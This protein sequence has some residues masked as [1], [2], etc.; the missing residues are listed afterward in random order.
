MSEHPDL[1]GLFHSLSPAA[2]TA[3][4]V[5]GVVHPHDCTVSQLA[6][7]LRHA[8][9]A[10]H[11]HRLTNA[12]LRDADRELVES[13]LAYAPRRGGGLRASPH[14]APWLTMQAH[15]AGVLDRIVAGHGRVHPRLSY[16][17]DEARTAMALRCCTVAGRFGHI[18]GAAVGPEEWGFLAEPGAAGLLRTLPESCRDRALSGCLMRV[19]NAATPPEP[20]IDACRELASDPSVFAAEIAFIRIL[21][22]RLDEVDSRAGSGQVNS[23]RAEN[24][25]NNPSIRV[26]GKVSWCWIRAR[27]MGWGWVGGRHFAAAVGGVEE[28]GSTDARRKG[29]EPGAARGSVNEARVGLARAR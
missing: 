25:K 27:S 16:Y 14:W 24:R 12:R 18:N 8:E 6:H 28:S 1:A 29:G 5:Y 20:I 21:Q 4:L 9:L 22:G 15:R 13:G 10:A 17:D 7:I 26:T 3:A 2:Q 23:S 11:G 19:I